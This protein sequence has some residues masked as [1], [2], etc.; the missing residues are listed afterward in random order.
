MNI[1]KFK[2]SIHKF[3]RQASPADLIALVQ[4]STGSKCY[5]K[6][7][8]ELKNVDRFVQLRPFQNFVVFVD[9]LDN[10]IS[11]LLTVML[12]PISTA[13]DPRSRCCAVIPDPT[14][15]FGVDSWY[16]KKMKWNIKKM[17]WKSVTR[18]QLPL[19]KMWAWKPNRCLSLPVKSPTTL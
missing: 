10:R 18:T 12:I 1:F 3:S 15:F 5:S 4:F 7:T 9:L 6:N 8:T 17:N 16:I 19:I 14:P 2:Q 11:G 13:C